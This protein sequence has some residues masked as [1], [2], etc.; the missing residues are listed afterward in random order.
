MPYKERAKSGEPRKWDKPTYK[1]VNWSACNQSLRKRGIVTLYFPKG[2]L[3][4]QFYN[5]Y[6]Y[7]EG[8]SGRVAEYAKAYVELMF[9]FYRLFGWGMCQV[10]GMM[11]DYWAQ[12]HIDLPVPS[13]GHPSDLFAAQDP[14]VKQQCNKLISRLK[15]GENVSMTVDSAGMKSDGHGEWYEHQYNKA[16]SPKELAKFHLGIDTELNCLAV[17]V[18]SEA[19]RRWSCS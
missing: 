10:T 12:R 6:S 2:D 14:A 7:V 9:L 19:G 1:V 5:P 17:E 11:E 4:S 8:V 13:F 15:R 3:A 16:A 18:T